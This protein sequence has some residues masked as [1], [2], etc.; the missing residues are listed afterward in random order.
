MPDVF[1]TKS[2]SLLSICHNHTSKR[3]NS[4]VAF[5][6]NPSKIRE[7]YNEAY[8]PP[9]SGSCC[10]IIL[11]IQL[12]LSVKKLKLLEH[13]TCDQ[14]ET[15]WRDKLHPQPV[16]LLWLDGS[17]VTPDT[18][19]CVTDFQT[20]SDDSCSDMQLPRTLLFHEILALS[21]FQMFFYHHWC[22]YMKLINFH[23]PVA[24][25]FQL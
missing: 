12:W 23:Q 20:H 25:I 9:C 21:Y 2:F 17:P 22:L 1:S 18:D 19:S 14:I 6:K 5:F 15:F 24:I 3:C 8:F 13:N 4:A 7:T 16:S 10:T 11:F